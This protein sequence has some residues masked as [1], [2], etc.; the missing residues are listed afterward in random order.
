M[1]KYFIT[2]DIHGFFTPFMK[3]LNRKGFDIE[4]KDHILVI[5][6]DIFDRGNEPLVIYNFLM[7]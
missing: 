5:C 7:L 3:E 1:K 6:G 2:S 4:K